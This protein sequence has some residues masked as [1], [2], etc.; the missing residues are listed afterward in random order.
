M[1]VIVNKREYPTENTQSIVRLQLWKTQYYQGISG[2][3]SEYASE[4]PA[5]YSI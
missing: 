1:E 3:N 2:S 4:Y 5:Q